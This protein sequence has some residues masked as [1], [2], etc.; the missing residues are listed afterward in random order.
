MFLDANAPSLLHLGPLGSPGHVSPALVS[1]TSLE[2]QV[3]QP[4]EGDG[5]AGQEKRTR[6]EPIR[7]L[8]D[9]QCFTGVVLPLISSEIHLIPPS[10]QEGTSPHSRFLSSGWE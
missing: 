9:G 3:L 4:E 2:M 1:W 7:N 10:Y 5:E 8:S 6:P